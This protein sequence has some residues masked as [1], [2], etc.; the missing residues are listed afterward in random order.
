MPRPAAAMRH[1][2]L[3]GLAAL[4]A[5]LGAAL[6][7]AACL[8]LA[9]AAQTA[10]AAPAANPAASAMAAV[11]ILMDGCAPLLGDP[12]AMEA[13]ARRNGFV[14]APPELARMFTTEEGALVWIADLPGT[15]LAMTHARDGR[16]CHVIAQEVDQAAAR[17]HFLAVLAAIGSA[18][19]Q[20]E[21]EAE[22]EE[23]QNGAP[24][25][26]L[27]ARIQRTQRRPGEAARSAALRMPRSGVTAFDL[28]GTAMIVPAR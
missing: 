27:A 6:G 14:A 13:W 2:L 21:V 3:G 22:Q 12:A 10:P 23:V 20:V 26:V 1:R 15:N 18:A 8:P 16:E 17:R 9:A 28:I 25:A 7:A 11:H 19:V 5:A 24:V 4:W